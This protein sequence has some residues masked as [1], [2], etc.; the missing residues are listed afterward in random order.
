[1]QGCDFGVTEKEV[2]QSCE[3]RCCC[4]RRV[5]LDDDD[6]GDRGVRPPLIS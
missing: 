3:S 2:T 5:P 6:D 1:M 4:S